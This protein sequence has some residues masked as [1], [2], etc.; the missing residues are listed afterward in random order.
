MNFTSSKQ[1]SGLAAMPPWRSRL[2]FALLLL[3]L[4]ALIARAVYL[5]GIHNNFLQQKGDERYGRVIN[6]NAHR[7]MITD[8]YGEPLAIS[9]PVAA[10]I[11]S[12]HFRLLGRTALRGTAFRPCPN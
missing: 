5:Q 10:R 1:T 11:G 3:G 9:T 4:A 8:R 2:L 7:G 12:S 6:I